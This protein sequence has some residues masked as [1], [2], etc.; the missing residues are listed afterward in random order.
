MFP[1]IQLLIIYIIIG[2]LVYIIGAAM[3]RFN[4]FLGNSLEIILAVI[5]I[6][7]IFM[8]TGFPDGFLD[9]SVVSAGYLT[10]MHFLDGRG[11]YTEIMS[12]LKKVDST[13]LQI[14][15]NVNRL[16]ID[17]F[18]SI[19]IFIGAILFLIF[20]P[21]Y[22]PIKYI[23]AYSL[24]FAVIELV[25]RIITFYTTIIY[26]SEQTNEL[27]IVSRLQSRQLP[28]D[29]LQQV[30]IESSADIL[31]LHPY[32]TLFSSHTDFTTSTTKVLRLD[33]HGESI[34]VT[35]KETEEWFHMLQTFI[36]V[37]Q[38]HT[39]EKTVLPFYH[40]RNIKRLL[41]KLYFAMT[42]K[43]ISAYTGLVLI[44]YVLNTPTFLIVS[45]TFLYWFINLY[46]SDRVLKLAMDAKE[47]KDE[48]IIKSANK[49]FMKT[50]I[51]NVK[52]YETDT[53]DFNGLATGM[54]IGRSMVT[55]TRAT[56]SLPLETIEGIL[57]HEA[58]HV[59]K[60]DVMW[61]QIIRACIMLII[62]F[63]LISIVDHINNIEAYAVPM[64]LMI[65]CLFTVI[66]MI[67][68]FY[69]QWM[70]VRADHIGAT[71]LN[72][73]KKQM[74]KS[75]EHLATAQD[76]TL[77]KQATY[78]M[79]TEERRE[80][81]SSLSRPPWWI[82]FIEFQMMPHPPMYWRVNTLLTSESAY[83]KLIIKR[84]FID[85]ILESIPFVPKKE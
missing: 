39:D 52:V 49:I 40:K 41:G 15:W 10:M 38:S 48:T 67:Q 79:S 1:S 8:N 9:F 55:L 4:S 65:W 6:I 76:D 44:L 11:K 12:T 33:F 46:I 73:G 17:L 26:I 59:K 80:P 78:S 2:S 22:S 23:I 21:M 85:R 30:T 53:K 54:N 81:T 70:E 24:Y 7:V 68:S 43:G 74:G 60:R 25:K 14:N 77:Q 18:L 37:T 69:L 3:S 57:A 20:G 56:L 62:I 84:W 27:F 66:P 16:I 71:F 64:F 19:L 42:V 28:L 75:L 32:L 83:G 29:D 47:I 13:R 31:K 51:P 82:R 45:F 50:G 72:D 35:L 34:Y 58:V 63:S 61:G 36:H 5:V